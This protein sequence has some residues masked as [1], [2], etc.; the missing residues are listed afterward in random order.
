M[1]LTC[2][3]HQTDIERDILTAI[4]EIRRLYRELLPAWN[5]LLMIVESL[6]SQECPGALMRIATNEWTHFQDCVFISDEASLD[7]KKQR[8]AEYVL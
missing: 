1:L 3:H 4:R 8:S 6:R 7:R 5:Q 2:D